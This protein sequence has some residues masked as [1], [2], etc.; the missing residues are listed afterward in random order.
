MFDKE[1]TEDT[2]EIEDEEHEEEDAYVVTRDEDFEIFLNLSLKH[3]EQTPGDCS[4]FGCFLHL[5]EDDDD[6]R[7]LL[8][9]VCV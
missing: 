6:G 3:N 4:C 2:E 5:F 1:E 8:F 7:L 9:I